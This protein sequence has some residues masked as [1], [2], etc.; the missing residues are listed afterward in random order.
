MRQ[1]DL[2]K[3]Y[4]QKRC[5]IIDDMPD[6]RVALTGML[7]EFGAQQIDTLANGEQAIEACKSNHYD[8][9]LCDYNLG[10]GRDGQQVLEELRYRNRLNNT[11][12]FVMVTSESSRGM[13][14][15]ALEYQPDD[16]ITKPITTALL[17]TRL[18]RVVLRNRE[19]FA[20]K[21]AMDD[22]DYASAIMHCDERLRDKTDYRS[23]CLQIQAEMNLR[24]FNFKKAEDIY[25]GVLA[26]RPII[27][28][29]LGLG[30]TQLAKKEYEQAEQNLTEVI[31]MDYRYVE[32]HDLLADTYSARGNH[33]K[34]QAVMQQAAEI[35]PKSVMRQ[36]RLVA[37]AK[38]NED[39][40][41]VLQ[42]SRQVIRVARN[43]CYESPDD[44]FSLAR[45]LT[46]LSVGAPTI[47]AENYIKETFEI[48]GRVEKREGFDVSA[49]VQNNCIKSRAMVVQHNEPEATKYLQ[50]AQSLIQ[51]YPRVV[52]P[53]ASIDYAQSLI[54]NGNKEEA[55]KILQA[56]I[57]AN[58]DNSHVNARIDAM[59]DSPRSKEGR[60]RAA[61]MTKAGIACYENKAY[62][63]AIGIFKNAVTI[64][65]SHLGLNLNLVQVVVAEAKENGTKQQFES[66]CRRALQRVENINRNDPQFQRYEYLKMQVDDLFRVK[67]KAAVPHH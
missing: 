40:E 32:A 1:I 45:E 27:W 66:M 48:L 51:K 15:G 39:T 19:L 30:K 38:L 59:S 29:K 16:Y 8:M 52:K 42:A 36:R 43:S 50:Q 12:I 64:F 3:L 35:S 22:K 63:E 54:A 23:A 28:A 41:A 10:P 20:I 13:V 57:E 24:L 62:A 9:V 67:S 61:D 2:V 44:Y 55:E 5:L 65:P 18:D 17:R 47:T 31:E 34:A 21:K 56:L 26:E 14:L 4:S 60:A 58:P 46:E 37:L 49:N 33:L 7:R 53:E 6:I 11:S 25:R